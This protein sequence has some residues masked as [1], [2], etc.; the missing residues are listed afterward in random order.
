MNK[1]NKQNLQLLRRSEE[2]EASARA[3][4]AQQASQL[5]QTVRGLEQQNASLEWRLCQQQ[6][7]T[8]EL[9][10]IRQPVGKFGAAFTQDLDQARADVKRL[11]ETVQEQQSVIEQKEQTILEYAHDYSDTADSQIPEDLALSQEEFDG[12]EPQSTEAG[13]SEEGGDAASS[14]SGIDEPV[15]GQPQ[16][17]LEETLRLQYRELEDTNRGLQE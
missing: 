15:Q 6:N 14:A 11:Q 12:L 17:K 5:Q 8:A 3:Q 13:E 7:K 4:A 10:E 9:R 1:L 2:R 16:P